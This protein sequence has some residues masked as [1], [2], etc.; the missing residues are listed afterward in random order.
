MKDKVYDTIIIGAG[1]AGAS[2][3]YFLSNLNLKIALIEKKKYADTP[4]RCAEL[5]PKALTMLY[6]DK[7]KGINNEISHME[8]YIEGRLVNVTGSEG[9]ILDRN[10]FIDF[11]I[12]E[13]VKQGG[14]YL[15]STSFL[16]ASYTDTD[17]NI[18]GCQTPESSMI[19]KGSKS[20]AFHNTH[21]LYVK[22]KQ[23]EKIACLKTKI[24][25]GADGPCSMVARIMQSL[26]NDQCE[27]LKNYDSKKSFLHE[28]REN[29]VNKKSCIS[30]VKE[31][32]KKENN[33]LAG[34]QENIL[35]KNTHENHTKIFFYPFIAGGYGWLFP[36]VNSL[37]AGIA[38][39]MNILKENGLKNIYSRFKNELVKNE[40]IKGDEY[41]NSA[42]S[43]LAPVCGIRSRIV[44]NNIVLIG[45]AAGLCNPITGAG[46]YNAALSAKIV[47]EKIKT[48]IQ[49]QNMEV[50]KEAEKEINDC[51]KTSLE[52]ALKKRQI[53]EKNNT[54]YD[55]EHLIKKT[56]V[57]FKDYWRER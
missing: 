25:A 1:P 32:Q 6:S 11:L 57:S 24:L 45:D 49:A 16:N 48:A 37:N 36:K 12:K 27:Q 38:V 29:N 9:Y 17:E 47:S 20:H 43:G 22:I 14:D 51:F 50:L 39:N 18:C 42:I 30:A 4:V 53:L 2:L 8:T 35:K 40:I 21:E 5:V 13:F 3:A 55:F 26:Y 56:W 31:N 52:H 28:V 54:C 46:N 19:N 34:F 23:K 41:I 10:I 7:I 33:F 15:N 44:K